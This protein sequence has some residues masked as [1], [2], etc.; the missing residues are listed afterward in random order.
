[1]RSV[2]TSSSLRGLTYL[3]LLKSILDIVIVGIITLNFYTATFMPFL[4]GTVDLADAH[5]VMGWAVNEAIPDSRVEIQVYIDGQFVGATRADRLRPDVKLA[6]RANDERHGFVVDTPPLPPGKH[7]VQVYGARESAGGLRRTS[8]RIGEA[9][10][11]EVFAD[12]R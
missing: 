12:S 8:Q 9:V 10:W 11:F 2:H 1:M 3:L 5:Q 4:R 7:R 6:A